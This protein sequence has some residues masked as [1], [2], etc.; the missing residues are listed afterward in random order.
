MNREVAGVNWSP[1]YRFP[2]PLTSLI[3]TLH[4]IYKL[5]YA[6]LCCVCKGDLLG[7]YV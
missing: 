1:K 6:L 4:L 5:F 7:F 3:L 2:T